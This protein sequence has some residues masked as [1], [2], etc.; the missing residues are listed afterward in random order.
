[1]HELKKISGQMK[2]QGKKTV[3][4]GHV[5]GC[6]TKNADKIANRIDA[7][8]FIGSG[9]FH[10]MAIK[11]KPVYVLDIEK[12]KIEKSDSN[13]FEKKRFAKIYK[14][15]EAKT[16]GIILSSKPGQRDIKKAFWAKKILEKKDKKAF[17]L[18]MSE[19]SD[20]NLMGMKFDA[21][22]N[23]ACPRICEDN[24]SRPMINAEDV[25]LL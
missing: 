7:F 17:V 2:R 9:L 18:I 1:M 4:G 11:G 12:S 8:L 5:L 24:F 10:P 6:W 3:I 23:T 19:I 21:Y 16:F 25:D 13:L 14:C 22:I 15:R 20:R